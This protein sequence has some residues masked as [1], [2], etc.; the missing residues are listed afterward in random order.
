LEL[1]LLNDKKDLKL[2]FF[3]LNY[4][5]AVDKGFLSQMLK[6]MGCHEKADKGRD[7]DNSNRLWIGDVIAWSY[8]FCGFNSYKNFR[9]FRLKLF[10][11]LINHLQDYFL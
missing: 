2:Q 5:Y 9:H 11:S 1:I 3:S 8:R 10:E 4:D 7:K 6:S